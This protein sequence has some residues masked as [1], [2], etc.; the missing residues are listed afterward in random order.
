MNMHALWILGEEQPH[1]SIGCDMFVGSVGSV[2]GLVVRG[3]SR[4]AGLGELDE[5][6]LHFNGRNVFWKSAVQVW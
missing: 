4:Q 3:L 5:L 2:G 6:F 1:I